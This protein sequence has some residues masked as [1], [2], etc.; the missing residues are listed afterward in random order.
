MLDLIRENYAGFLPIVDGIVCY[1]RSKKYNKKVLRYEITPDSS[2]ITNYEGFNRI[3]LLF[4]TI[5]SSL[6][7]IIGIAILFGYLEV[8]MVLFCVLLRSIISYFFR[9]VCRKKGYMQHN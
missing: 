8:Y 3:Q 6:C 5:Y 1:I 9:V 2:L 7:L 4:V